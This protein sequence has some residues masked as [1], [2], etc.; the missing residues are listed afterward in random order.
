M[1][2]K[3]SSPAAAQNKLPVYMEGNRIFIASGSAPTSHILKPPIKDLEDT[4]ANEAFCMGSHSRL[5]QP[6]PVRET[7]G[8]S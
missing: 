2:D 3:V 1:K 5:I 6:S 4:V 8:F 7:T